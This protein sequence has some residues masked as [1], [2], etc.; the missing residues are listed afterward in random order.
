ML[1]L[2]P[3]RVQKKAL[4]IFGFDF[5][6]MP[7]FPGLP[8]GPPLAPPAAPAPAPAAAPVPGAGPSMSPAFLFPVDVQEQ[9]QQPVQPPAP[10]QP[11]ATPP[12]APGMSTESV[13]LIAGGV[14][15]AVAAIAF[16][17]SR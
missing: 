4:G 12:A 6:E 7:S 10:Q 13:L 3:V 11:Q 2:Q 5:P 15:V 8:G 1:R 17:S 14:V 16:F 9:A